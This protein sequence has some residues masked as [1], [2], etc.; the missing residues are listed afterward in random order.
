MIYVNWFIQLCDF[1]QLQ[2]I[3]SLTMKEVDFDPSPAAHSYSPSVMSSVA[4]NDDDDD[5]CVE[6]E[7]DLSMTGEGLD[8]FAGT[9]SVLGDNESSFSEL[10]LSPSALFNEPTVGKARGPAGSGKGRGAR[11]NR[12]LPGT[13]SGTPAKKARITKR[14][15]AGLSAQ[16]RSMAA[17][18]GAAA[19]TATLQATYSDRNTST[20]ASIVT[21][22]RT[23]DSFSTQSEMGTFHR[24]NYHANGSPAAQSR[25][26]EQRTSL[27]VPASQHGQ[28]SYLPPTCQVQGQYRTD[29]IPSLY[30]SY[31]SQHQ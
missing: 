30:S 2:S 27:C 14:P 22:Q 3:A 19:A 18:A 1:L 24:D 26:I 23:A 25:A 20:H 31:R 6:L 29:H 11:K 10:P 8:D 4:S 13:D 15:R 21:G 28:T 7:I 5:D 17:A 16:G 12:K 9:T